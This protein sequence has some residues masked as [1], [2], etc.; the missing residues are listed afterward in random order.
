M[1]DFLIKK[2]VQYN[3]FYSEL[4]RVVRT[5]KQIDSGVIKTEIRLLSD[6]HN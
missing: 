6:A 2:C 1:Q 4:E 5:A 3:Q